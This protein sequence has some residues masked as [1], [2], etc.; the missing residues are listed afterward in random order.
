MVY[1]TLSFLILRGTLNEK[2]CPKTFEYLPIRCCK[3]SDSVSNITFVALML[4]YSKKQVV[5]V[6]SSINSTKLK[7]VLGKIA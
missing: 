7:K 1:Y 4:P 6:S 2:H 3:N 5:P